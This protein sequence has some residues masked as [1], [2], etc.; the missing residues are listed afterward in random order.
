M[1]CLFNRAQYTSWDVVFVRIIT[2]PPYPSI[3]GSGLSIRI[4]TA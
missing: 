4:Q 2:I 3:Y 1:Q